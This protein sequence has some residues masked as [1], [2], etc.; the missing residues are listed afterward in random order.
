LVRGYWPLFRETY[1]LALVFWALMECFLHL[2]LLFLNYK[3]HEIIRV[4]LSL[5]FMIIRN[6]SVRWTLETWRLNI[7]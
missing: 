4:Q 1:E 6:I 5:R 3:V 7:T 2:K